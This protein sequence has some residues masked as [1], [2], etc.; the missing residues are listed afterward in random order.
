[1]RPS[2]YREP[3]LHFLLLGALLFVAHRFW[4]R[5]EPESSVIVVTPALHADLEREVSAELGRPATKT[6]LDAAFETWKAEEI[7]YREGVRLGLDD[8]DPLVRR[9]VVSKMLELERELSFGREPSDAELDAWLLQ[10][11]DRYTEPTRYDF[12][13]LFVSG[14]NKE[15]LPRAGRLAAE[16][17]R[18]ASSEGKGDPFD[19]GRVFERR[20][21]ENLRQL[22]GERFAAQVTTLEPERWRVVE[23]VHGLHVVRLTRVTPGPRPEREKLRPRLVRDWKLAQREL[24]TRLAREKY[25]A[26]YVFRESAP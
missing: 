5:L 7:L 24:V 19:G 3:L 12:E 9:R 10:F 13:Q 22:F 8:D 6:E 20:T 14:P 17:E 15:A 4:Q 26:S 2:L 23:S 1:V 25:Q 21:L 16:L 18:G 11:G